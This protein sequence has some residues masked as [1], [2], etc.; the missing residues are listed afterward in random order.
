MAAQDDPVQALEKQRPQS[1][2]KCDHPPQPASLYVGDLH[3]EVGEADLVAAF[4]EMGD[5]ASVRVCRDAVSGRSLCYGYVNFFSHFLA[6]K[7]LA[8]LN[9]SK[10][11]G[12]PMR[13][14]WCQRD[15]SRRKAGNA[16]L[17]VKNLD[18][19]IGSARLQSIFCQYGN[20]LS[21]KVAEDNGS[22]KGF[23]FVQFE[24]E[25]SAISALRALHDTILEGKKIYVS[26]FV[27][28]S[29]R[30]SFSEEPE[31]TNLYVKNLGD[32]ITEDHLQDKF[33][34]Y[35]KV[36]NVV[37]MKDIDGKSRG[38]GFVNFESPQAAK[39]AVEALNGIIM[40]SKILFVG[41]AQKKAERE[42]L[43]KDAHQVVC[44]GW[45]QKNACNLYVKN[46]DLSIDNSKLQE[47]FSSFGTITSAKV[48]R[49]DNGLSKGF[50]FVCFS[51]CEEAKR[52]L[53]ALNGIIF[54]GKPLYVAIAQQK[55]DHSR[56][57]Q[58]YRSQIQ[59]QS[60]HHSYVNALPGQRYAPPYNIPLL[61]LPYTLLSQSIHHQYA[62]ANAGL[63]Y[64]TE[65]Y[66]EYHSTSIPWRHAQTQVVS[67][68]NWV[69]G[70]HP[71]T[72]SNSGLHGQD[73][74]FC[75]PRVS[76]L[77]IRKRGNKK[78]LPTENT[79]IR[80]R[81]LPAPS[82]QGTCTTTLGNFLYPLVENIQVNKADR[83]LR[84]ANTRTIAS[85]GMALPKSA[86]CLNY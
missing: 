65:S 29:E 4:S 84:D 79:T 72:Y 66:R 18:P 27:K 17:F 77:G 82:S 10:L 14:M 49:E 39:K 47:C 53:K 34:E 48:M 7:A 42:Q 69:Y 83:V 55:D 33:S 9:Y 28:K 63:P 38:F 19:S 2:S 46:L 11:K 6:S 30:T 58:E 5:I 62:G 15:P 12:K 86:R 71:T 60:Q 32:N 35:G 67:S 56:N 1:P 61:H 22:S 76:G 8:C 21:C 54:K 3:P 45:I 52:A 25:E 36:S 75:Q 70:D 23:G 80:T 59:P 51:N 85:G 37:I 81:S 68:K 57:L 16:N 13:I 41:R 43:L 64:A 74:K 50:G 44:S 20:I 26:K 24:S 40:G 78:F 73:Q 31:F